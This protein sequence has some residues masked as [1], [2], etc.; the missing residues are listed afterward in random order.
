MADN[1]VKIWFLLRGGSAD[2]FDREGGGHLNGLIFGWCYRFL[3]FN[4]YTLCVMNASVSLIW[5]HF[6]LWL[7]YCLS[8]FYQNGNLW[9]LSYWK[10]QL[11]SA[12]LKVSIWNPLYST[13]KKLQVEDKDFFLS[14]FLLL[15]LFINTIYIEQLVC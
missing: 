8:L 5:W 9:K 6:V 7:F 2:F 1:E 10:H 14:F 11:C 3:F 15:F 4:G 12:I 13:Q